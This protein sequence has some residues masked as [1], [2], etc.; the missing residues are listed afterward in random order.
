MVL[1]LFTKQRS[2]SGCFTEQIGNKE[3]NKRSTIGKCFGSHIVY[4]LYN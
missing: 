2:H 1:K 4:Y 3:V